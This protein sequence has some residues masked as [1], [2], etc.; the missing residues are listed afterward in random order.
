MRLSCSG[1]QTLL[2]NHIV[3]TEGAIIPRMDELPGALAAM[4]R[5][6]NASRLYRNRSNR[7]GGLGGWEIHR[8][9]QVLDAHSAV[10]AH[11]RHVHEM[12]DIQMRAF[13]PERGKLML[14]IE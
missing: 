10:F 12:R 11:K 2:C 3:A 1:A 6:P 14:R 5:R 9:A 8:E 13:Q 7:L 4:H